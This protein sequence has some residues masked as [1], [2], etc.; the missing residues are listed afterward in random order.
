M[1]PQRVLE[2]LQLHF[3]DLLF[4][5][6]NQ[7]RGD[8][9]RAVAGSCFGFFADAGRAADFFVGLI[10]AHGA[11]F[12]V[13][14][15]E[16]QTEQ[17]TPAQ[18]A[19]GGELHDELV[20]GVRYRRDQLLHLLFREGHPWSGS[21]CFGFLDGAHGAL[22]EQVIIDGLLEHSSQVGVDV[23]H[24]AAG[25][26]GEQPAQKIADVGRLQIA[27]RK[28][29]KGRDDVDP[30]I[31][32]VA[33]EGVGFDGALQIHEPLMGPVLEEH[34]AAV[35]SGP[36]GR[37]EFLNFFDQLRVGLAG[38]IIALAEVGHAGGVASVGAFFVSCH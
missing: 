37:L 26:G 16:P 36:H 17:F 11:A 3:L 18:A 9:H 1:L 27:E 21:G 34:I 2:R 33:V 5:E 35:G 6:G 10:Y 23:L 12:E 28:V 7:G 30:H 15:L 4:D 29:P 14:V 38:E 24:R 32:F 31:G 13:D 20:G 22:G 8:A 19:G 25:V